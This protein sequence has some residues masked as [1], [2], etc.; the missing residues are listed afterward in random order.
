MVNCKS[1]E[2]EES[3]NAA[4]KEPQGSQGSFYAL[5]V[6]F[7][8]CFVSKPNNMKILQSSLYSFVKLSLD[9]VN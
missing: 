3:N 4:D 6:L 2:R 7:C 1:L 8:D 9:L 5:L